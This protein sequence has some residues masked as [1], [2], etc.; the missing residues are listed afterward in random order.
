[1]WEACFGRPGD[2]MSRSPS[3]AARFLK[4]HTETSTGFSHAYRPDGL[5]TMALSQGCAPRQLLVWDR[6]RRAASQDSGVGGASECL[7]QP[8]VNLRSLLAGTSSK[9]HVF[10]MTS[11]LFLLVTCLEYVSTLQSAK[12]RPLVYAMLLIYHMTGKNC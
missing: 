8:Q 12:L 3:P 5:H 4:V 11:Y 6:R 7:I 2:E 1:M 9:L 10:P